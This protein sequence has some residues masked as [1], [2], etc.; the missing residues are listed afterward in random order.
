M[1]MF[2]QKKSS[3]RFVFSLQ[4]A[5][6]ANFCTYTRCEIEICQC[7]QKHLKVLNGIFMKSS[8]LFLLFLQFY[9]VHV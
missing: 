7:P 6:D 8:K 9:T 5:F 3:S 1:Y 2:T 4:Q